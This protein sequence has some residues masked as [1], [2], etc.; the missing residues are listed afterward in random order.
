ME[1]AL[2]SGEGRR[3]EGRAEVE[4]SRGSPFYRDR[5]G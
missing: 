2:E 1:A 4:D 3:N 5:R